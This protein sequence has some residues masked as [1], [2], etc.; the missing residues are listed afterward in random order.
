VNSASH[1]PSSTPTLE[2]AAATTTAIAAPLSVRAVFQPVSPQIDP[3]LMPP[4]LD[5]IYC[6]SKLEPP[7]SLDACRRLEVPLCCHSSAAFMSSH[8]MGEFSAT[9]PC[10]AGSPIVAHA[11]RGNLTLLHPPASRQGACH[12][13]GR[14]RGDHP[15][16]V[17]SQ[18]AGVGWH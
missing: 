11:L 12:R 4:P 7:P 8:R 17:L 13:V 10:Q 6:R 16:R 5:P 9:S 1:L 15:R 18:D 14:G 2:I 3:L